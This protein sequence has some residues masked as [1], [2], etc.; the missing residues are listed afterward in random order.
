MISIYFISATT[1]DFGPV[2]IGTGHDQGGNGKAN[3]QRIKECAWRP[4]SVIFIE[5]FKWARALKPCGHSKC[6]ATF[7]EDKQKHYY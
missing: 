1:K 3:N 7:C 6:A 5:H 2:Q 4:K